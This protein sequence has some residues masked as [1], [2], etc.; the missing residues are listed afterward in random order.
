M[1]AKQ[2]F[3]HRVECFF[4]L[5]LALFPPFVISIGCVCVC[6]HFRSFL[7][8]CPVWPSQAKIV[9]CV[10]CARVCMW[11]CALRCG[12]VHILSLI[13]VGWNWFNVLLV[14]IFGKIPN[15]NVHKIRSI[16]KNCHISFFERCVVHVCVECFLSSRYNRPVQIDVY[17]TKTLCF[18]M[19]WAIDGARGCGI[20]NLDTT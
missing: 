4:L 9:L 13:Y 17:I 14:L 7:F 5:F 1:L 16:Q 3:L 20:R 19:C 11:G 8:G 18:I 10:M 2:N 12:L 15:K 6:R